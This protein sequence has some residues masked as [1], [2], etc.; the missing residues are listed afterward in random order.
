MRVGIIEHIDSAHTLPGR[1]GATTVHGHTYQVVV[2]AQGALRGGMVLDFRALR[3]QAREVL[4]R[5]DHCV[6]NQVLEVPS[7]ENLAAAIF[8]DLQA[9][10]PMLYSV[11]V[12]EGEGQWA[13]M[14]R[15][16]D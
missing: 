8:H 11:C 9:R 7:N 13:E 16:E 12:R 4:D 5:Y 1:G 14:R 15:G 6:L 2:V 3:E 10:Q